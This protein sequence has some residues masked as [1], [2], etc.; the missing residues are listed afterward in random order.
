M[1]GE[2]VR[3]ETWSCGAENPIP[4]QTRDA[5]VDGETDDSS[6]EVD[7]SNRPPQVIPLARPVPDDWTDEE[8]APLEELLGDH[9]IVGLGEATHVTHE[10]V[11]AK[12]RVFRYLVERKGFRLLAWEASHGGT[13]R[14]DAALQ[15]ST[16]PLS[17]TILDLTHVA[18]LNE[19]VRDTLQ[20]I[21]DWNLA[22]PSDTV[23]LF[24]FDLWNPW[25]E[26]DDVMSVLREISMTESDAINAQLQSCPGL[27]EFAT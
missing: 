21:C 13:A 10:V 24:G 9:T 14:V 22:H 20:D 17:T 26:R 18:W 16:E 8:L 7:A 19:D 6:I 3:V 1:V 15:T 23:H 4:P 11:Q 2:F 5:G 27:N 25:A 12:R